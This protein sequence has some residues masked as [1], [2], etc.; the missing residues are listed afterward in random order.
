MIDAGAVITRYIDLVGAH[1]LAPLQDLFD[2]DLVATTGG[3][4]FD[5][6]EWI[7][8][9]DRLLPVLVRNDIRRVFVDAGAACVIY[10]FVTDTEAGAV[11]CVE[12][13]TVN[14]AGRMTAVELIFEKANWAHVAAALQARVSA[15]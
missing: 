5:K 9:L 7:A 11:P 15:R 6:N 4:T 8:A 10:D 12:W 3:R 13:I 2:D 1:D 14:E